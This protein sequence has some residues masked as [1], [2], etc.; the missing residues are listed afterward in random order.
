MQKAEWL[1]EQ[2]V[3]PVEECVPRKQS[4]PFVNKSHELPAFYKMAMRC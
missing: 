2:V 1:E 3:R 4:G